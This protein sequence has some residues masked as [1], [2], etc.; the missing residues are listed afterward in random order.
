LGVRLDDGALLWVN[1]TN[2]SSGNE[3]VAVRAQTPGRIVGR[4]V[5]RD[6]R[7]PVV[8]TTVMTNRWSVIEPDL[9]AS[10]DADGRFAFDGVAPGDLHDLSVDNDLWYGKMQRVVVRTGE[11]TENIELLVEPPPRIV[12]RVAIDGRAPGE[13]IVVGLGEFQD[14]EVVPAGW[15]GIGISDPT[16]AYSVR[17]KYDRRFTVVPKNRIG[18]EH[19]GYRRFRAEFPATPRT[20]WHWFVDAP[21]RGQIHFDLNLPSWPVVE[22]PSDSKR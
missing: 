12:G 9:V 19:G 10:T 13:P 5:R 6:N 8:G 22:L 21:S 1:L 18:P 11:T 20:T 14:H 16:G 4:V 7:S 17:P 15:F 3:E 2:P